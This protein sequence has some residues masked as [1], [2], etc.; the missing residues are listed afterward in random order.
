MAP[1]NFSTPSGAFTS[2]QIINIVDQTAGEKIFFQIIE[3]SSRTRFEQY[4]SFCNVF[5]NAST[6]L[7][8]ADDPTTE[9]DTSYTATFK[10]GNTFISWQGNQEVADPIPV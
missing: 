10:L 9:V 7:R 5:G 4:L 1:V 8:Y 3:S 6:G 2:S